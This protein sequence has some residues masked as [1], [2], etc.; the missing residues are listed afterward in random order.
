MD[1]N[2]YKFY[3]VSTVMAKSTECLYGLLNQ[4]VTQ[5]FETFMLCK[6]WTRHQ[7]VEYQGYLN[8]VSLCL[9]RKSV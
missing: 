2:I 1:K 5:T 9:T 4:N 7:T 8:Y 3:I 6:Y